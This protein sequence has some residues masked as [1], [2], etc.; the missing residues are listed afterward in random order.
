M[1]AGNAL[2]G[3]SRGGEQQAYRESGHGRGGPAAGTPASE[4]LDLAVMGERVEC[5]LRRTRAHAQC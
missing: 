2:A 1:F 5:P 3:N 4:G